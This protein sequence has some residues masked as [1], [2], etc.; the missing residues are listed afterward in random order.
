MPASLRERGIGGIKLV[1]YKKLTKRKIPSIK[2]KIIFLLSANL[3]LIKRNIIAIY[4]AM[5]IRLIN[6]ESKN[7]LGPI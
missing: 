7:I 1:K 2:N 6:P 5:K 3:S 4:N